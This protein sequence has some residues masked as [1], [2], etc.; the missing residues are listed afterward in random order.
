ML[1]KKE[2][3]TQEL[4]NDAGLGRGITDQGLCALAQA[5]CG[6]MLSFLSLSGCAL[7]PV[8]VSI[9]LFPTTTEEANMFT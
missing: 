9:V 5:G 3:R 6:N 7:A 4:E 2:E 8:A 1:A